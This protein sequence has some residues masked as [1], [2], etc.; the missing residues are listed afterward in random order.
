MGCW[1]N[2]KSVKEFLDERAA[3][4]TPD[5]QDA[6]DG[7]GARKRELDQLHEAIANVKEYEKKHRIVL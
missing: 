5:E 7:E 2:A 1:P 3:M 6:I 4:L